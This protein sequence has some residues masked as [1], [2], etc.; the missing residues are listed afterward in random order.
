M[1]ERLQRKKHNMIAIVTLVGYFNYGNRLQNFALQEVC[2]DLGFS[3]ETIVYSQNVNVQPIPIKQKVAN[4]FKM[5]LT[6][7][8]AYIKKGLG[9]KLYKK[10]MVDTGLENLRNQRFKAF[11]D[12]YIKETDFV[13]DNGVI[14]DWLAEKYD[15]FI[16][17][18][19]QVWHPASGVHSDLMFLA[20]AP[21]EKRIAYAPS[22]GVD[23][24][25]AE[26]AQAYKAY[27]SQISHISVREESG[28][29][30]VKQLINK[31]AKVLVDPTMLLTRQKWLSIAERS[32][33]KPRMEYLLTYF[34]GKMTTKAKSMI[35]K[36]AK[37]NELVIVQLANPLAIDDYLVTP[38]E[39]LDCINS[40]SIVLT[41][42]FHAT[43]F[44]ILFETPFIVFE[45][46]ENARTTVSRIYTLLEKFG[47]QSREYDNMKNNF[48]EILNVDF[49]HVDDVLKAERKKSYDFL[50]NVFK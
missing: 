43:V 40:A 25:P 11:T 6:S 7:K 45:R 26:F 10:P 38:S 44:S 31:E 3:V 42:S 20:F 15:F 35:E 21:K 30:I 19:D 14:P 28:K 13:I 46:V 5:P 16:T 41:D 50:N 37:Q 23:Q 9:N 32:S 29:R 27:L 18:S 22:F 17:G 34:L 4:L 8:L 36:I 12:E 24:I 48:N 39:F 2:K 49:S 47:L 1:D 33:S